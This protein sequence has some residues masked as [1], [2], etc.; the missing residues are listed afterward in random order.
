[1]SE[2]TLI[3]GDKN[4]S[5]WS[6]RPWL[7]LTQAGIPFAEKIIRLNQP[8]TAAELG[9][10]TPAGLVPCLKHGDLV[11]WD[12]L[13][14]LEYAAETFP[15]AALW[16]RDT[17]RR[18]HARSVSAEMHSG[19]SELRKTW[20]MNFTARKVDRPATDGAKRDIARIIAVWEDCRARYAALGPF[21]FGAFSIADAM[22]APVVSRFMTYGPVAM[23]AAAQAW[24]QMLFALPAMQDWAAGAEA[25]TR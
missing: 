14:I 2:L 13:A 11:I 8:G 6:L 4:L 17:A 5:S 1:M 18:A 21:L 23:P 9:S 16:P 15:A 12:S 19:F 25:E 10:K 20:P 24:S 22:Y 3:I 7:A